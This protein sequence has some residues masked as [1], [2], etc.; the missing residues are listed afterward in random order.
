MALPININEL[1][2]GSIVESERLEFKRG[3]SKESIMHS[4]CAFANDFNNWG[5]GYIIVGIEDNNARPV[6]PPIGLEVNQIDKIYK[7]LLSLCNQEI[8]PQYTPRVEHV[9]SLQVNGSPE[10]MFDSNEDRSYFLT[11]LKIHPGFLSGAD[12]GA[13]VENTAD[14][15][16]KVILQSLLKDS[17]PKVKILSILGYSKMT[18]TVREAFN[19]LLELKHIQYTLPDKP[20]SKNQKYVITEL[21]KAS[22]E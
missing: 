10:V 13:A 5:G 12:H 17:L 1:I 21:G 6:L 3:W 4:I 8:H 20:K 2:T 14:T 7:E 22:L 15:I 16:K 11:T 19:R 18:K 9:V